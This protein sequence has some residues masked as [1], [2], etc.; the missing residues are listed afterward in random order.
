[1]GLLLGLCLDVPARS[2]QAAALDR[3]VILGTS[4]D[5]HVLRVMPPMCVTEQDVGHLASVLSDV[6]AE[7]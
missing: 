7:L 4:G 1:M 5:P 3:G 2:V 6:L